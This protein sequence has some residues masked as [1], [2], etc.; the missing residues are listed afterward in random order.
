MG[1][2]LS[3]SLVPTGPWRATY[4]FVEGVAPRP[5]GICV[6]NTITVVRDYPAALDLLLDAVL[7]PVS[8]ADAVAVSHPSYWK[9]REAGRF[10]G[11]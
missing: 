10:R 7:E 8:E 5:G 9:I 4:L 1:E 6:K 2:V 11:S 3:T